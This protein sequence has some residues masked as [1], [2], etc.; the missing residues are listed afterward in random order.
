MQPLLVA[1][2]TLSVLT[3]CALARPLAA[4]LKVVDLPDGGRKS[5]AQPTP[6]IGGIALI[7]PLA[8]LA[9]M[10][11]QSD[12]ERHFLALAIAAAGFCLLGHLDDRKPLPPVARLIAGALLTAALLVIEPGFVLRKLALGPPIGGQGLSV[13]AIP[14]T[15]L[16]LVGLQNAVNMADGRDGL[17]L[18]LT[19]LWLVLLLLHAPAALVPYLALFLVGAAIVLAFNCRGLLFLGDAGSHAIGALLGLLAIHVYNTQPGGVEDGTLGALS[20]ASWFLIPVIDCLRLMAQRA[21]AGRSPFDPDADH[22]HHRLDRLWPW[23]KALAV[24]LGLVAV[25]AFLDLLLP[26]AA[27]PVLIVLALV[28]YGVLLQR[29][30]PPAP[31]AATGS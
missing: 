21:R 9:L 26:P 5:H 1:G 22:L 17:V 29:G 18:S 3:I 23:P 24:Y 14:F 4:R 20:V 2:F 13:L 6:L 7:P 11:P 12:G 16:C 19:M 27:T 30:R 25:P 15:L 10:M 31:D 8:A 28:A